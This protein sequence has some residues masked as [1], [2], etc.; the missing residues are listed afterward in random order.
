MAEVSVQCYVS[1]SSFSRDCAS[2]GLLT[3]TSQVLP[4]LVRISTY[5]TELLSQGIRSEARPVLAILM[6]QHVCDTSETTSISVQTCIKEYFRMGTSGES[7][8]FL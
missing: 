7:Q 1:S 5:N 4:P 3:R 2:D 8:D 6:V